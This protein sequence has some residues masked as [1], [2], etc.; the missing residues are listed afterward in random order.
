MPEINQTIPSPELAGTAPLLQR[1]F[2]ARRSQ[3]TMKIAR[4]IMVVVLTSIPFSVYNWITVDT[5]MGIWFLLLEV[6]VLIYASTLL[7]LCRTN[8]YR[9]WFDVLC[10]CIE[11]SVP[12]IVVFIDLTRVGPAYALTS[13]ASIG[14]YNVAIYISAL[15]LRPKLSLVA[16]AIAAA[17]FLTLALLTQHTLPVETVAQLLSLSTANLVQ[18][19]VYLLVSG[20]C[21]FWLG[22]SLHSLI[23]DLFDTALREMRAIA[24]LG[25]HVTRQV[26]DVL[27]QKESKTATGERREITV[28]FC[29]IRDFTSF[30]ERQDPAT[31][32]RMLNEYYS[33]CSIAIGDNGGVVNKFLGDGLLAI[34]GAPEPQNDHAKQAA[35]AAL[36]IEAKLEALRISLSLP[37]LNIGIG[38]HSGEAIVG[39]VGSEERSEYT[40]IGDTVNLASRIEGLNKQFGTRILLSSETHSRLNGAFPAQCVGTAPVKGRSEQVELWSIAATPPVHCT[41]D[42]RQI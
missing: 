41:R 12:T 5:L 38:I 4:A 7:F 16:G 35:Q 17:E 19:A 40:A 29:D 36:H 30:A 13:G 1:V 22:R 27:L 24:I 15:R 11:A 20:I 10:T 42:M 32:V 2:D 37:K 9:P 23:S 33:V 3:G 28:L 26:A 31:V 34:F 21:A 6:A 8:R 25:R 14:L 39:I 18:R